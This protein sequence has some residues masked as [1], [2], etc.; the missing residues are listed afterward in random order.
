M[1][2]DLGIVETWEEAFAKARSLLAERNIFAIATISAKEHNDKGQYFSTAL[3]QGSLSGSSMT[4]AQVLEDLAKL[5]P[6]VYKDKHAVKFHL[7][8][9]T[10]KFP[11]DFPEGD[12]DK[13]V[14]VIVYLAAGESVAI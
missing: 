14:F 1:K 10:I 11:H 7:Y 3:Q 6:A 9:T 4:P 12:Q 8:L 13:T 2:E 5:S